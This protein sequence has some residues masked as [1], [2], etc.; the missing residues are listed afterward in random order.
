MALTAS[1]KVKPCDSEVEGLA[2]TGSIDLTYSSTTQT[3]TYIY[4]KSTATTT[5]LINGQGQG[6]DN[7]S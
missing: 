3:I 4:E 7:D 5:D 2:K 6:I 1:I